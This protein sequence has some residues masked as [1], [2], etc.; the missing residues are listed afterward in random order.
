MALIFHYLPY[1]LLTGLTALILMCLLDRGEPRKTV[2]E[3]PQRC[4]RW[5]DSST[6]HD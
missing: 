2:R 3:R 1:I 5:D 6:R 4:H